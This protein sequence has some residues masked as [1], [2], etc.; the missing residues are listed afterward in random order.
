MAREKRKLRDKL[1]LNMVIRGDVIT[2]TDD[3]ALFDLNKI[4]SKQVRERSVLIDVACTIRCRISCDVM[5]MNVLNMYRHH[6]IVLLLR[7]ATNESG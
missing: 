2:Q 6:A 4:K 7:L 5:F 3:I 1:A